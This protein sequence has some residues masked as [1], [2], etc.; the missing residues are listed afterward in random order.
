MSEAF[1]ASPLECMAVG[2]P[3]IASSD[4]G[5]FDSMRYFP[6]LSLHKPEDIISKINYLTSDPN[7]YKRLCIK[8]IATARKFS[9]RSNMS[10]DKWVD[11]IAPGGKKL[12]KEN[13]SNYL[14]TAYLFMIFRVVARLLMRK[15]RYFVRDER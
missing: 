3:V 8:S 1:P 4:F 6:R 2:T 13:L 10:V 15:F 11:L 14:D 12:K 9:N 5:M 7:L